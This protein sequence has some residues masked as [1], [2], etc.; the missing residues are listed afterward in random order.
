MDKQFRK[1]RPPAPPDGV[2]LTPNQVVAFN[3][4]QAR[5]WRN[6]TQQQAAEACAPYLGARW[7]KTT[8][9]AA[10]RSVN[11]DRIRQFDADE[12]VAFARGF[13]LPVTWF[14]LPPPGV[15]DGQ[16]I[17]L[18]TPD[19]PYGPPARLLDLV[20]GDPDQA[21]VV[22][23]RVEHAIGNMPDGELTISQ[24]RL[25]ALA[26]VRV[27]ALAR[28]A[29]GKLDR[30]QTMLRSVANQIE[31]LQTRARANRS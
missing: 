17:Y 23:L 27:E 11:G 15:L 6:W 20:C 1:K 2:P 18:S 30:W 14:L 4:V 31:D 29:L 22:E 9:S 13:E 24:R 21:N 28:R 26:D 19:D 3:L 25:S 16:P 12:I 8:W 10:E 7:S 5:L